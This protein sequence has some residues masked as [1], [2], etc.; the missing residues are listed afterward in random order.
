MYKLPS[1]AAERLQEVMDEMISRN[2]ECGCQLTIYLE[3]EKVIDL[4]SGYTSATRDKKVDSNTLFPVFS[5]GKAI[6]STTLHTILAS[7]KAGIDDPVCKYWQEFAACGKDFLTIRHLLSHRAGLHTL[8]QG[9][10]PEDLADW[11]FM[12]R[13]IENSP[14]LFEG[15]K[16]CY[17]SIS[18]TWI[19]GEIVHRITGVPFQDAIHQNVLAP[20]GIADQFYFGIPEALENHAAALDNSRDNDAKWCESFISDTAI[21]RGFIPAANG[22]ATSG[23]IAKHYSSLLESGKTQLLPMDWIDIATV[24]QRDASDPV[25]FESTWANFGLGYALCGD[26]PENCGS[27]FGH[28]GAAGAQGF[29]DKTRQMAIGFTKNM[30]LSSHPV[31]PIRSKI[32]EIL[33]IR[34]IIW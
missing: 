8:H 22:F 25:P 28:G 9:V 33:G 34:E 11:E 10:A 2:E 6:M 4:T 7:G 21:R 24:P 17:H 5:V 16:M 20:L 3:G 32:S 23:A 18:Y 19:I 12:C 26:T 1:N 15:K 14:A 29:A 31:H 13:K 30:P 27:R